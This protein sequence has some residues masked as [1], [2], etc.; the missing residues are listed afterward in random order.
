MSRKSSVLPCCSYKVRLGSQKIWRRITSTFADKTGEFRHTTIH[1][2]YFHI[3]KI[4]SGML[5]CYR[6]T[7]VTAGIHGPQ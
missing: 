1:T 6:T 5:Q 3:L 4:L 7:I 2:L